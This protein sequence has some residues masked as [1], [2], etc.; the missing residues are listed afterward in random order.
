MLSSA[1]GHRERG[2]GLRPERLHPVPVMRYDRRPEPARKTNGAEREAVKSSGASP[3]GNNGHGG[4]GRQRC[5][6]DF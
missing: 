5:G 1:A 2:G 6:A 3:P 4:G